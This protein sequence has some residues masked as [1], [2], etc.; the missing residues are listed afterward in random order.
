MEETKFFSQVKYSDDGCWEWDGCISNKGYG[1]FYFNGS[2]AG[3][4]AHRWSYE[5]FVENPGKLMV[6]HHCDNRKCV[7]PFHLFAGTAKDNAQD[8]I[9]KKRQR[10]QKRT[11]CSRGHDLT[12][13][14][15][16]HRGH[17]SCAECKRIRNAKRYISNDARIDL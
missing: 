9:N 16:N 13:M 1:Q 12:G 15:L 4:R 11:H 5:Y 6:C 17:R 10:F 2:V 3:V 7:N 8:C 14:P